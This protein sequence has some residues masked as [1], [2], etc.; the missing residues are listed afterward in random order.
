VLPPPT[1]IGITPRKG[2][3]KG[4]SVVITGANLA[5]VSGVSFGSNPA[6][7]FTV[8]S[9]EQITAVA[10]ASKTLAAVPVTVTTV[11]GLA[12]SSQAFSY[13][14]C[15]VPR[16]K[17]MKLEAA[18]RK[19]RS[20]RCRVAGVQ[21]RGD[22]TAK[23]GKVVKQRPRPGRVIAPGGGVRVVLGD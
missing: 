14:G 20:S 2:S 5:S 16:L 22:A 4:A 12:T 19:I 9:E 23:T 10:P 21:K 11:A 7:S 3:V 8:D 1:I 6:K 13:K 18:K 17:G 15:V